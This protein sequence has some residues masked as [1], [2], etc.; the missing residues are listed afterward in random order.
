MR[1][2]LVE[3]DRGVSRFIKKG[4]KESG[5]VVDTAFDGEEGLHLS[6][7]QTYDLIVLDILLPEINGYEVLKSIR[8]KGVM[9]P[10]ICLTAKDE[11]EDIVKG[12]ELG[13]DDYLVKPFSFT[14][15]LARIKAVLRRGQKDTELSN[16]AF[17]DLDLDLINR[18]ARRNE[19]NIELS[20]KEFL[21]LEYLMR[22][23]GQ[24]LTRTMI[25]EN[26]WGYNFDTSS[27]IVDVHINHLRMKVDKDFH[28]KLIHTIK[29]VGYVIK[30]EK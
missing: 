9:T 4:L 18:A 24:I 21:L 20:G 19:E 28:P 12:L 17:E 3:D 29:G 5:Y 8:E 2:L 30:T 11:K 15:L 25:L 6:L 16:L 10:V 1:V 26:V 22:N 23:P 7:S 27:N 14:E 13:A